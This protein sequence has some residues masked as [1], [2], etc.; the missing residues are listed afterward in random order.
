M[1]RFAT[2]DTTLTSSAS[3]D[4]SYPSAN[5]FAALSFADVA[6]NCDAYSVSNDSFTYSISNDSTADAASNSESISDTKRTPFECAKHD[7]F[8]K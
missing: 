3:N 1:W 5:D 8:K 6:A 2:R 4:A 7:S